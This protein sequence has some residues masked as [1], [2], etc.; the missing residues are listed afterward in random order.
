M[1]RK[2]VLSLAM[3]GALM[4]SLTSCANNTSETDGSILQETEINTLSTIEELAVTTNTTTEAQ[5][6]VATTAELVYEEL[7]DPDIRNLKWG[8]SLEEVKVYETEKITKE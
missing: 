8:M 6:T 5:M 2:T 1:R 4:F 7:P 3:A